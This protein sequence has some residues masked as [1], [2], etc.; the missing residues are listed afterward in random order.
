M[1]RDLFLRFEI[2]DL[3]SENMPENNAINEQ[4]SDNLQPRPPVVVVL[5]HVDHG[6]SS[7]LEAIRE[8]FR[9]TAKES[10]G[11]TQHVGAYEV[12]H[13]GRKITFLDTPGHEAFS[14]IRSRGANV[15]DIAILVVAADEGVKEQTKEA[16]LHAKKARIPIIVALNKIDKPE[17]NP[18]RVKRELA[19]E[20]VVVEFL[21]GKIP[22]VEVSAKTKKGIGELLDMVLLIAELEELK[23]NIAKSAE[24]IVIEA[25]L[26]SK[27]GPTATLL[28]RDG[29]L[30]VQDIVGTAST[31]GKVRVIEDFQGNQIERALPSMPA[32]VRGFEQVPQVGEK[33]RTFPDIESALRYVERKEKKTIGEDRFVAEAGKKI[34]NLVLKADVRS[35]IEA[36]EYILKEI[37]QQEII[38]RT[39]KSGVGDITEG[40][41]ELA[42]NAKAYI[43]GFRVRVTTGA[44]T[45]AE[46]HG[47]P[48]R[49]FDVIYELVQGVRHFL[50]RKLE[51]EIVKITLGKM[52]VLVVFLTE[53]NRQIVGGRII[54]GEVQPGVFVEVLRGEEG[55]GK[56]KVLNLQENKRDIAQARRGQE[57]G[58]LYEGEGRI[59]EG[60]TLVFYKREQRKITL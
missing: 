31:A 1:H 32:I 42:R 10:G 48:L 58:I 46:H 60:D 21:G 50:E 51:P 2:C 40:D 26:D 20:D 15:A 22:A 37:P 11:I 54:E 27:R 28:I 12:D 39:I 14:A 36:V 44:K 13:K 47:I 16:I 7:L 18:E 56:G 9:I 55:M 38:L 8:D 6:K 25:Y 3:R 45:L 35:S 19:R 4:K 17:A 34:V 5:G 57:V 49:S 53:K 59:K 52:R 24:G 43:I 29:V 33:F 30:K 41:V 23:A